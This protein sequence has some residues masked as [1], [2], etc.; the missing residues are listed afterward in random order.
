MNVS[1][2]RHWWAFLIRGIVALLFAGL[3][4]AA[5]G[6]VATVFVFFFGAYVLVD[7][8]FATYAAIRSAGSDAPWGWLLVAG[9]LGIIVGIVMFIAPIVSAIT[10]AFLVAFWAI[11]TGVLE[12]VG[13]IR[14]RKLIPNEWLWIIGGI[15]FLI[16]PVT[17]LYTLALVA[18][19]YAAIFG[20]MQIGLALR[21]RRL[22]TTLHQH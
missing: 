10:L 11:V 3:A 20:I 17:A 1:I 6:S 8:I 18:G 14:L 16:E 22:G 7:G 12:I 21:L 9:I 4:F 15:V 2:A 5:P 13:A 19:F